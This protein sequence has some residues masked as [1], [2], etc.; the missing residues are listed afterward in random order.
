MSSFG[1]PC[2][3]LKSDLNNLGSLFEIHTPGREDIGIFFPK[4]DFK[5]ISLL[6]MMF[7]MHTSLCNLVFQSTK[8]VYTLHMDVSSGLI[9][10]KFILPLMDDVLIFHRRSVNIKCITPF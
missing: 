5:Y 3:N 7:K 1:R 4:R 6:A 10:L 2:C 9:Q 8:V